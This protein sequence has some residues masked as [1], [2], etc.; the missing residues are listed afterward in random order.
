[1]VRGQ[2]S[3][4]TRLQS[5][6]GPRFIAAPPN[7]ADEQDDTGEQS[8]KCVFLNSLTRLVNVKYLSSTFKGQKSS[9]D[10]SGGSHVGT[11]MSKNRS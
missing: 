11:R 8:S 4:H 9:C 1:M 2:N 10:V 7:Q 3:V 5:E 6:I